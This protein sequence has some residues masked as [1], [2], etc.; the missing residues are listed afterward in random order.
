MYRHQAKVDSEPGLSFWARHIE[1]V[2]A[3]TFALIISGLVAYFIYAIHSDDVAERNQKLENQKVC[4]P[5]HFS[6]KDEPAIGLIRYTC[7]DNE[8]HIIEK[9]FPKN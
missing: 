3:A 1:F 9:F 6:N 5:Y 7:M 4:L 8:G 2:K